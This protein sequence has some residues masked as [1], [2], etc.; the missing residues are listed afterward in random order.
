MIFAHH[1][2]GNQEFGWFSRAVTYLQAKDVP[3]SLFN[4]EGL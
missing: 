2:P 1:T 3:Q 4:K